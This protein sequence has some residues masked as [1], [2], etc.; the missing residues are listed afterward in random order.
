MGCS[1]SSRK[2]EGLK[3]IVTC[4]VVAQRSTVRGAVRDSKTVY[5]IVFIYVG[6]TLTII[7]FSEQ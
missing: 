2:V 5:I 3:G 1:S 7:A 4:D 6:I